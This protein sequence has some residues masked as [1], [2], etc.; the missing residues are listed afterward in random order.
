MEIG[1]PAAVIAGKTEDY[2]LTVIRPRGKP[3]PVN[4]DWDGSNP[5]RGR[6]R[7]DTTLS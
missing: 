7:P 5:E 3:Q 1:S 4:S 2:D 6:A